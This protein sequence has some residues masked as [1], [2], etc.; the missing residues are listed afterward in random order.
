MMVLA[1]ARMGRSLNEYRILLGVP[2]VRRVLWN[3]GVG[4]L[5]KQEA[6]WKN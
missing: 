4:A 5:K 3:R 1:V 6:F 2:E